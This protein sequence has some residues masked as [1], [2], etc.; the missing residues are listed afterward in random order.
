MFTQTFVYK[1][2][3]FVISHQSKKKKKTKQNCDDTLMC[4]CV[5]IHCVNAGANLRFCHL[6]NQYD[7]SFGM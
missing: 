7:H 5:R 1:Y 4:V 3:P 6:V 2:I